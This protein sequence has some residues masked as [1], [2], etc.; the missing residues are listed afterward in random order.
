MKLNE[1][2]LTKQELK[3]LTKKYM[4]ETYE[5]FD[6]IAQTAKDMYLYDEEGNGYLDFYGGVAVNSAGSCNEKVVEAVC[7]QV[8]DIIHT[9]NYPYTVPQVL[10]AK[11][12]CETI[13]MDKIFYQNSG[14]EANEA[15]IKMARKYGTDNYGPNKY[16][17]ITAKSSFHGRTYGAMSATGQPDN[18]CQL[19]FKPMLPGFSYADFNDV[20]SFRKLVTDDTI[21]IMIEPVQ[22][23]GGV[24]PATQEFIDGIKELCEEKRLL[25][26]FDEIQTGWCRTGE[27]MAYMN[28]NVKPDIVSMAKAM[29]GGM[30]ISAVCASKEV[31]KAFTMGS[32]GSTYG[33]NPVCCA[34]A[35]AQINELLDRKLADNAKKMGEYFMNKL[36]DLPHVKDV[37]G[38]GL[39]VGVEFDLPIGL[40]IKHNCIDRKLLVTLIGTSIIRMVPPLI[41]TKADCDK[42]Y[43]I[44]KESVQA[45]LAK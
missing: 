2:K 42:A 27:V 33:G 6:F 31:S 37:R 34:A 40:D 19:G 30:P 1:A 24:R 28:Y 11:L 29:G 15:M 12:I 26:L 43:E 21:A 25:L 18:G 7:D 35:Y 5:R 8:K 14:A 38:K 32:H 17:I 4:I 36:K 39:L 9:F 22:G 16:H 41:L 10:L 13:G 44:L 20:D 23:E 45:A 3:D